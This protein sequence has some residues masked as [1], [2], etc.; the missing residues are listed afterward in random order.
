M[1]KIMSFIIALTMLVT[2]SLTGYAQTNN[3]ISSNKD[4]F[5]FYGD[6]GIESK[7]TSDTKENGSIELSQYNDGV[8]IQTNIVTPGEDIIKCMT[9]ADV[10]NDSFEINDSVKNPVTTYIKASD[11]VEFDGD[12]E[13][14]I[15][16]QYALK[17]LGVINYKEH[18]TTFMKERLQVQ[19]NDSSAVQTTYTIRSYVGTI[20]TLVSIIVSGISVPVFAV[21]AFISTVLAAAGI[22]IVGGA[23]NKA[24]STTVAAKKTTYTVYLTDLIGG[25]KT[26]E[27]G[28]RYQLNDSAYKN[29][30]TYYEGLAEPQWR[31]NTFQQKA[32]YYMYFLSSPGVASWGS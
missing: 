1:K 30:G 4:E 14:S 10:E 15:P 26:T 5:I 2:T 25:R 24:L 13:E 18:P 12:F 17:K 23:I 21:N 11:Y 7:I 29:S 8:L 27:Y 6:D 3:S 16:N 9:Y 22:T 20:V 32:Y 19:S 28:Y 31:T